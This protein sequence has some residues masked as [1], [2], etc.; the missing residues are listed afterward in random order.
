MLSA[1]MDTQL[2]KPIWQLLLEEPSTLTREECYAVIE[3]YHDLL[4]DDHDTL[5]PVIERYL[6]DCPSRVLKE[7]LAQYRMMAQHQQ[8]RH[9]KVPAGH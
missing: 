7:H 6:K 8:T 3:Y 2:E 1:R 5:F 9:R 4:G